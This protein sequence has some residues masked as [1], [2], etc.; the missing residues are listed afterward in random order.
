MSYKRLYIATLMGIL[1]GLVCVT[2]ASSN[3]PLPLKVCASIF[4]GRVLIGIVIGL[5][6]W[7]M[8][9]ALHGALMGLIVGFPGA[10]GAMMTPNKQF[11]QWT[12]FAMT[13]VMGMIYGVLIELV[14]SGFFKARQKDCVKI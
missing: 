6:A 7:K 5:S 10:I 13:L 11:D 1:F 9:W 8:P 3:G 12:L 4:S 2:M 14:T